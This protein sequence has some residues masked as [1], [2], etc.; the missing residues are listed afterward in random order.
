MSVI[1]G[2]DYKSIAVE[3]GLAR[4]NMIQSAEYLF[5]AVYDVVM[6]QSLQPEVDL[7]KEFYDSYLLNSSNWKAP[8][9]LLSAV[10]S[11]NGHVLKR[12]NYSS[13]NDYFAAQVVI[14]P[15][16]SVPQSWAD[17]CEFAGYT[18]DPAYIT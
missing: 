17:L 10:S 9:T 12:G 11:I 3:Y 14:D 15:T 16:F 8:S 2:S 18:V 6:L 7:L 5:N 4:D 13:L 1:S